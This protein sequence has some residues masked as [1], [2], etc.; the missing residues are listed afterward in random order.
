MFFNFTP[1]FTY[2]LEMYAHYN[3]SLHLFFM[4]AS[5]MR[6]CWNWLGN[7]S[8]NTRFMTSCRQ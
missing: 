6:K 2:V 3:H 7:E 4:W 8:L 5:E 1:L